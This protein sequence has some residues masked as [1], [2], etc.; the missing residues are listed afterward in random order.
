MLGMTDYDGE[1]LWLHERAPGCYALRLSDID[2]YEVEEQAL[3]HSLLGL[4]ALTRLPFRYFW[5]TCCCDDRMRRVSRQHQTLCSDLICMTMDLLPQENPKAT[6]TTDNSAPPPPQSRDRWHCQLARA[7]E[8]SPSSSLPALDAFSAFSQAAVPVSTSPIVARPPAGSSAGGI[9]LYPTNTSNE[10]RLRVDIT[11]S[12]G[13][14]RSSQQKQRG[15]L[16]RMQLERFPAPQACD[17]ESRESVT[18]S[19]RSDSSLS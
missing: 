11:R 12:D 13:I 15:R 18:K 5:P 19:R 8:K 6:L 9:C 16:R 2:L 1:R 3:Q 4:R 14:V 10:A 17:R 7:R